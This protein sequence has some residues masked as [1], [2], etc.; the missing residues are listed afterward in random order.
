[1]AGPVRSGHAAPH[2]ATNALVVPNQAVQ[3]GQNGSYVYVVKQ[4]RSVESRDVVTG[5]R[6]D[7]DTVIDKASR[8][9][10]RW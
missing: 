7:M 3:T 8:W 9:A 4:D 2:H 5:A 10:R 1:M 6:V